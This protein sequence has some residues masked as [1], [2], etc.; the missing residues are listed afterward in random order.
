VHSPE[1]TDMKNSL[2]YHGGGLLASSNV[3]RRWRSPP[4]AL[5]R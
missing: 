5:R 2:Q 1:A 3:L 4:S